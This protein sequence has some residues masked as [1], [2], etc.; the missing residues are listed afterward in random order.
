MSLFKKPKGK[1]RL[2]VTREDTDD[3]ENNESTQEIDDSKKSSSQVPTVETKDN[4]NETNE[5]GSSAVNQSHVEGEKKVEHKMKAKLSF[6]DDEEEDVDVFK[7]KKSAYSRRIAK[8]LKREKKKKEKEE[9]LEEARKSEQS[10]AFTSYG[11]DFNVE[12]EIENLNSSAFKDYHERNTDDVSHFFK[13]VEKGEIPSAKEIYAARKKREE[14]RKKLKMDNVIDDFIA[15]EDETAAE[16]TA[17]GLIDDE[18]PVY[19]EEPDNDDDEDEDDRIDFAVDREAIERERAKEAFIQAQEEDE[20]TFN[21]VKNNNDDDSED[22]LDLWEKE[23]IRKGVGF[24]IGSSNRDQSNNQLNDLMTKLDLPNNS[25]KFNSP[26]PSYLPKTPN[27][28]AF[29]ELIKQISDSIAQM[30]REIDDDEQ[31]L[32]SVIA[33]REQLTKEVKD[34]EERLIGNEDDDDSP[35]ERPWKQGEIFSQKATHDS[36]DDDY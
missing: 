25:D 4:E 26:I 35:T 13:P 3:D 15:I 27:G 18:Q 7:V 2:R 8:Q 12:M 36:S 31:E 5:A 1:F 23:Q 33:E 34:L 17:L 10:S 6:G 19:D 16:R 22:E 11:E 24:V 21:R 20:E 14:D 29:E 9:K 32:R 30:Q 28:K